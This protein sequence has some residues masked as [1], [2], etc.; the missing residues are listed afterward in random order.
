VFFVQI[1]RRNLRFGAFAE[2]GFV[3]FVEGDF[4]EKEVNR[5]E[6]KLDDPRND[7]DE[8]GENVRIPRHCPVFRDHSEFFF[9]KAVTTLH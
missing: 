6:A 7:A 4:I 1:V 8:D 5:C 3:D 9:P 2:G